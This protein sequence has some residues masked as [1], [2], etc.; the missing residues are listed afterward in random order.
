MTQQNKELLQLVLKALQF[1][2]WMGIKPS[3][4]EKTSL[5]SKVKRRRCDSNRKKSPVLLLTLQNIPGSN[6]AY[7]VNNRGVGDVKVDLGLLDIPVALYIKALGYE[8]DD[9]ILDFGADTVSKM[10]LSCSNQTLQMVVELT[11]DSTKEICQWMQSILT[12][13]KIKLMSLLLQMYH[14]LQAQALMSKPRTST[15]QCTL[16]AMKQKSKKLKAKLGMAAAG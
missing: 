7:H 2:F 14:S 10:S 13:S 5:S 4:R 6:I 8:N 16:V 1:E 3:Q 9:D 15:V 11:M 12:R